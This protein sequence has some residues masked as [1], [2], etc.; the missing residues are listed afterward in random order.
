MVVR[1][2]G[3]LCLGNDLG[4]RQPQ[5]HMHGDRQGIFR[6]QKIDFETVNKF[7]ELLLYIGSK[8]VYRLSNLRRPPFLPEYL[9]IDPGYLFILEKSFGD[10][11]TPVGVMFQFSGK[12]VA[13]MAVLFEYFR[14]FGG[15]QCHAVCAGKTCGNK[16]DFFMHPLQPS[17]SVQ[18]N[19][20][21]Q[22]SVRRCVQGSRPFRFSFESTC[23]FGKDRDIAD[24][25]LRK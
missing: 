12:P 6:N 16:S 10:Q 25:K 1:N 18:S 22:S 13:V 19:K 7:M 15:F 9:G 3:N 20:Q 14:P 17:P 2:G 11:K 24:K 5:R 8:L 23:I 4:Q 21:L